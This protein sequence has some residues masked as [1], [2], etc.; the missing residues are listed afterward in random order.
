MSVDGD[1][2]AA[3]KARGERSRSVPGASAICF[4]TPR[5]G[6]ERVRLARDVDPA[7]TDSITVD[8]DPGGGYD[9]ALPDSPL[10][11]SGERYDECG[12][13]VPAL[14]CDDCG[15]VGWVAS[16]CRRSRCPRCWRA[17]VFY[18]AVEGIT[19]VDGTR[20]K[21]AY[22]SGSNP[23][24]H[25]V[26]VS[27][28]DGTRFD[29]D[30]ALDRGFEAAKRFMMEVGADAGMIV[31]HPDR[32]AE[33]HRGDVIG[34]SS[35]DGDMQWK[36]ILDMPPEERDEYLVHSPHFH[37]FA[38]SD[39][40]QGGAVTENI[41]D[42]TGVV[43]ERIADDDGISLADMDALAAATAYSLSHAGL[44]ADG[45]DAH[46]A[47]YRYFGE[48]AN[49]ERRANVR[50]DAKEAMRRVAPDVL[51]V[52]FSRR[53]CDEP[54][55]DSADSGKYSGGEADSVD[56]NPRS[57]VLD[58]V[59][60]GDADETPAS[61]PA[62]RPTISRSGAPEAGADAPDW[63]A[64]N[65]GGFATDS[66]APDATPGASLRPDGGDE[67]DTSRDDADGDSDES[68]AAQS[69]A[70]DAG[71]CGGSMLPIWKIRDKLKND[72][73][74][75]ETIGEEAAEGIR[76]AYDQWCDM[77]QPAPENTADAPPPD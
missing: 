6:G 62:V 45:D 31:Y 58:S 49:I 1:T 44:T 36:D 40:I 75:R 5:N 70:D 3:S 38:V 46:R 34:H 32:I 57:N 65:T 72:D 63:Q 69:N 29:S 66:G 76:D 14:A 9:D 17:W 71:E 60:P 56:A 12:D 52:D 43:I 73:E 8:S 64:G 22:E 23:Y 67:S 68:D 50:A 39:F 48:T 61:G 51:G 15:S 11:G 30:D 18:M 74:W 47:A 28:P 41:E 54:V 4:E 27:F 33:E 16:T 37:V 26:I 20:R 25:H 77:G 42:R 13:D 35:G 2:S 59:F 24:N 10:P 53:T 21:R 55:T 19:A 7:Y